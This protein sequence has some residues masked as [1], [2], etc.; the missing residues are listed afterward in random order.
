MQQKRVRIPTPDVGMRDIFIP[1][2]RIVQNFP[3]GTDQV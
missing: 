2:S 1:F 3:F